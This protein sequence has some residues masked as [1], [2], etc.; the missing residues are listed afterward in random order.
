[1]TK[2]NEK[3]HNLLSWLK[4]TGGLS[5]SELLAAGYGGVLHEALRDG[6]AERYSSSRRP[7]GVP[8]DLF[9]ITDAGRNRLATD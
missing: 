7:S 1:M 3:V 4:A 8:E 5:Y 2:P 6:L 9:R